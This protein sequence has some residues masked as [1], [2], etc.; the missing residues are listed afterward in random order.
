MRTHPRQLSRAVRFAHGVVS[1]LAGRALFEHSAHQSCD[2]FHGGIYRAVYLRRLRRAFANAA[3]R[4]CARCIRA[5]SHHLCEPGADG[6][7]KPGTRSAREV[8]RTEARQALDARPADWA[9][10]NDDATASAG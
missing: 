5:L 2:R 9:E 3:S 7:E 1:I 8:R 10:Q 6:V 4:V